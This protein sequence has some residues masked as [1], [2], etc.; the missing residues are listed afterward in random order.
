MFKYEPYR[1]ELKK[2]PRLISF[3]L[4]HKRSTFMHVD[5]A[6]FTPSVPTPIPHPCQ[7]NVIC[8][9]VY[10]CWFGSFSSDGE[11]PDYEML[12]G[13]KPYDFK[14]VHMKNG[15]WIGNAIIQ[16][17]KRA[18]RLI[19]IPAYIYHVYSIISQNYQKVTN[20]GERSY[21]YYDVL[22]AMKNSPHTFTIT[23]GTSCLQDIPNVELCSFP[24]AKLLVDIL[25]NL[26]DDF[27][28]EK[29]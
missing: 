6:L 14:K 5:F 4:M 7:A 28:K 11:N 29:K 26:F 19:F 15:I 18:R 23:D 24:Y 22:L 20:I 21:N 17:V 27:K 8:T 2:D 25:N 3:M 13:R 16:D 12:Q 10:N 9:S 1:P